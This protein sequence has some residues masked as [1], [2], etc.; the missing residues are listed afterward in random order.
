MP[1]FFIHFQQLMPQIIDAICA[2]PYCLVKTYQLNDL[3]RS[4]MTSNKPA[5]MNFTVDHMT[6]LLHPKLYAVAYPVFRIIFGVTP[7]DI[8]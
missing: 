5:F 3:R 2:S 7:D 6:L 1:P 4:Q 8:L